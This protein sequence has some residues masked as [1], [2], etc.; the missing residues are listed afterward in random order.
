MRGIR[1]QKVSLLLRCVGHCTVCA[2]TCF[3]G[4]GGSIY[5]TTWWCI[6]LPVMGLKQHR[7]MRHSGINK[8]LAQCSNQRR[9]RKQKKRWRG[10][11]PPVNFNSNYTLWIRDVFQLH[12]LSHKRL[13]EQILFY[14]KQ[15]IRLH[16]M[17]NSW[18]FT[19]NCDVHF[20]LMYTCKHAIVYWAVTA[21]KCFLSAQQYC[22]WMDTERTL[23]EDRSCC[24][25][26][27]SPLDQCK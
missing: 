5:S 11:F 24:S 10:I 6:Y 27:E 12:F 1:V 8:A 14:F 17:C 4:S 15:C 18:S 21:V 9:N 13:I 19:S 22:S 20:L 26:D 25:A 3:C 23:T 16:W 7:S 2:H